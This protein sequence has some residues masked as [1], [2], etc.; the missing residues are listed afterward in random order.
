MTACLTIIRYRKRFI[1]LALLAMAIHRLP[2]WFNKKISFY[3]L[4]GSGRN[5]SFDKHPDWQQWGIFAVGREQSAVGSQQP[6]ALAAVNN[7]Y[8]KRLYGSFIAGWF[9][10]FGC[11]TW[12]IFLE[13]TEGHGSWA[14]KEPF[15]QLPRQTDF[16]GPVAVLTRATIR[17]S[18]LKAFWAHVNPVAVKMNTAEGFV[19]SLGVGEIPWLR[20]ATFSI[21]QSKEAMKQFAYSMKEHQEVIIKTRKDKW[22][23]EDLFARFKILEAT[24]TIKGKDPLEKLSKL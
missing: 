3:K 23:S 19:T 17:L 10:F 8:L 12:T 6:A 16:D 22:Y 20:Q 4:L 11:E 5:G 24:G 2:L 15:G 1:P 18:K 9:K 13:P 7:D 21:W 14:G